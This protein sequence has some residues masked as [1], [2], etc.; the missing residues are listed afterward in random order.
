LFVLLT[1]RH[2]QVGH[3]QHTQWLGF[4]REHRD[5]DTAQGE[6]VAFDE[7]RIGQG[8]GAERDCAR[9]RRPQN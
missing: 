2:V 3:M 8:G 5:V 6:H 7:R 9:G 4:G 1:Q